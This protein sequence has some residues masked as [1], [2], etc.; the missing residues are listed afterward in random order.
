MTVK[1]EAKK[2]R[3]DTEGAEKEIAVDDWIEFGAFAK[4]PK[5]RKYGDTLHRERIRVNQGSS[6]AR[7]SW[8]KSPIRRE[9]IRSIYWW[10]ELPT[11]TRAL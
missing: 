5:G 3:A 7:S 4:P 2:F 9:S 1:A 11:T 10:I 6:P 8:R